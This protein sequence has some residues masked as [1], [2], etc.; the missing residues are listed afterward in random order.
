MLEENATVVR[1]ERNLA[2]VEAEPQGACGRCG[3]R[4]TCASGVLSQLLGRRRNL[5]PVDNG[6]DAGVGD[7]VVVGIADDLL[8]R[9]AVRAYLFPLFLA[10]T[11]SGAAAAGGAGDGATAVLALFGLL[12]G[13]WATRFMTGGS[14]GRARYRPR[15]LR[16]LGP[17]LS[18]TPLE[19][20]PRGTPS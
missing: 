5:I 15:M 10:V 12:T 2:W 6:L 17:Q 11:L 3:S 14:A 9:A 20:Q 4:G 7:R 13:L 19:L 8:L 16:R 18:V 1:L